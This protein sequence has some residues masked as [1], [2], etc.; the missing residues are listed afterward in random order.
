MWDAWQP[1]YPPYKNIQWA[2]RLWAPWEARSKM[3]LV[4]SCLASSHSGKPSELL[5]W[6]SWMKVHS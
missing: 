3:L 6:K 5:A 2:Q 1:V 4:C